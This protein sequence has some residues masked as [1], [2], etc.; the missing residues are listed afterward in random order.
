MLPSASDAVAV[1]FRFDANGPADVH[2]NDAIP[3]T[4]VVTEAEPI[5]VC[6]SP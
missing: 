1:I 5:Y 4:S 2:K 6:P 3:P